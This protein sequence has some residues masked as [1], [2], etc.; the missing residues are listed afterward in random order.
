LRGLKGFTLEVFTPWQGIAN[1]FHNLSAL[2]KHLFEW[3]YPCLIFAIGAVV[4][5]GRDKPRLRLLGAGAASLAI[6]YVFFFFHQ[7]ALGPRFWLE[8]APVLCVL[9]AEGI[10]AAPELIEGRFTKHGAGR[11]FVASVIA[12]GFLYA[13][14]FNLPALTRAYSRSFWNVTPKLDQLVKTQTPAGSKALVFIEGDQNYG[15]GFVF[16]TPALDGRIIYARDMGEKNKLLISQYKDRILF[17]AH[18]DLRKGVIG[19]RQSSPAE[20]NRR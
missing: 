17:N 19:I 12:I 1:M 2:S 13:M 9:T 5:V 4:F 20:E 10:M 6:A 7:L 15:S 16:N 18:L 8:A 14:I 11:Q 3:P